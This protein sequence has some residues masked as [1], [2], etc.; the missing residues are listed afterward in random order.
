MLEEFLLE[1]KLDNSVGIGENI[2]GI[3]NLIEFTNQDGDIPALYKLK[4]D[5]SEFELSV[6]NNIIIGISYKLVDNKRLR[7]N[8]SFKFKKDG[9]LVKFVNYLDLINANWEIDSDETG[10]RTISIS[11]S[12]NV[13]VIYNLEKEYCGFSQVVS[14]DFT[15]YKS[16]KK[17][18][19]NS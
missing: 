7:S 17:S 15:L 13:K 9:S 14:F 3:P 8:K 2:N 5:K 10:N 19:G 12:K 11:P 6:L 16:I 4:L 18:L 1:G